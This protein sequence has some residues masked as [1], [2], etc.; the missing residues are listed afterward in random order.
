[1]KSLTFSLLAVTLLLGPS[2]AFGLGMEQFGS[3][4]EIGHPSAEQPGWPAGMIKVVDH[5]SRIYST[6][7][8]GGENFYF[9]ANPRELRELVELFSEMRLRDH[10]I[11]IKP[12]PLRTKSFH[13]EGIVCNV[14]LEHA[15]GLA[16]AIEQRRGSVETFEP[17]LAIYVDPDASRDWWEKVPI[18]D[19]LCIRSEVD[20]WPIANAIEP[21]KRS[22]QF[23]KLAFKD[24]QPKL[25]FRDW[26]NVSVTLWDDAEKPGIPLGDVSPQGEYRVALSADERK[27]LQSGET[28]L[29]LTVGDHLV[30][31]C[32]DDCKLG[33]SYLVSDLEHAK[34][35]EITEPR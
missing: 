24:A 29:T 16:R 32:P 10:V 25:D 12:G 4:L 22:L 34:V 27:Q 1:M 20:G 23:A 21:P 15:G 17:A 8:N 19:Q 5:N 30:K 26:R 11:T 7:V 28:W 3:A 31:P 9:K 6:W 33:P 35:F 14:T 18:A 13:G 2:P